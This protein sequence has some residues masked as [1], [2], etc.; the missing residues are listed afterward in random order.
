MTQLL[1]L[2]F[3]GSLEHTRRII[4]LE[5]AYEEFKKWIEIGKKHPGCMTKEIEK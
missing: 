1:I 5:K 2:Y 3:A 4:L